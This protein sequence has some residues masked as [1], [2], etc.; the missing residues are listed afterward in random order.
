MSKHRADSNQGLIMAKFEELGCSVVD[1]SGSPRKSIRNIGLSDL[2][3]GVCGTNHL[4]EVKT[5]GKDYSLPQ[6]AF[7]ERWRGEKPSLV[8]NFDDVIDLVQRIRTKNARR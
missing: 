8:R 3:I 1:L 6:I 5:E 4:V 2:L 7:G